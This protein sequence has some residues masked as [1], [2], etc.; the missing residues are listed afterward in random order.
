MHKI[1]TVNNNML[2]LRP[3]LT[4]AQR[5]ILSNVAPV[6]LNSGFEKIFK[7]DNVKLYSTIPLKAGMTDSEYAHIFSFRRQAYIDPDD[8]GQTLST[9]LI[10]F[11][12]TS[13]RI[14]TSIDS[15]LCF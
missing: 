15:L 8:I 6:I 4:P 14:F 9:F 11:E 10:T 1:I 12:D 5:V 13:Y 7:R 2:N 3:M